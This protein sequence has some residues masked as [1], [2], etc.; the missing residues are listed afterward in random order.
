MKFCSC[1]YVANSIAPKTGIPRN[2]LAQFHEN[3]TRSACLVTVGP[4]GGA[5]DYDEN[6]VD[7]IKVGE[8]LLARGHGIS[9]GIQLGPVGPSLATWSQIIHS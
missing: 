5:F 3:S 9:F 7:G 1:T 4:D 8:A 6:F 2:F